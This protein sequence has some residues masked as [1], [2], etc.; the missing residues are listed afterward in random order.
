M[1]GA[2]LC[3]LQDAANRESIHLRRTEHKQAKEEQDQNRNRGFLDGQGGRNPPPGPNDP[4]EKKKP[5]DKH[6]GAA[7]ALAALQVKDSL[8]SA[9]GKIVEKKKKKWRGANF[10]SV[11]GCS[12]NKNG[13]YNLAGK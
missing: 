2:C 12:T 5:E 13:R 9:L 7:K 10:D 4:N 1:T 11:G 6:K 8:K 3:R